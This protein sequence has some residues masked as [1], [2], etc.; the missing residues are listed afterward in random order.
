MDHAAND[1]LGAITIRGDLVPVAILDLVARYKGRSTKKS[2]YD[3][4]QTELSDH[5][6]SIVGFWPAL[7]YLEAR[8][9]HPP[10]FLDTPVRCAIIRSL[11]EQ[12]FTRPDKLLAAIR[13]NTDKG[14]STKYLVANVPTLLDFAVAHIGRDTKVWARFSKEIHALVDSTLVPPDPTPAAL[15]AAAA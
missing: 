2:F 5:N 8:Y 12:M 15:E 7:E 6:L 3:L 11:T 9:P 1:A 10:V 4:G 14:L 13:E